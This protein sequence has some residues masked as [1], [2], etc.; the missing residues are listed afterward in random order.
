MGYRLDNLAA[1]HDVLGANVFALSYRGY[2]KSQG[3]PTES[4][5][6]QDVEAALDY[7]YNESGVDPTRVYIFGRS[8]GGAVAIY[9]GSTT[10]YPVRG[11]IVEN[12]FTSIPNMVDALMPI[13]AYIKPL[14][15][16]INWSSIDSIKDIIT[17]ILFVVGT[18]DEL[19]PPK[20]ITEL[21]ENAIKSRFTELYKIRGGTH[22]D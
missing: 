2:G 22:N 17:P 9:A 8:L 6:K 5:L 1:F 16:R 14:V 10:S 19:I 11:I 12:T 7:I 3:K 21:K 13:A 18:D 15:L 4:G 20:M